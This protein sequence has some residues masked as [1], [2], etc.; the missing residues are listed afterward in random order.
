MDFNWLSVYSRCGNDCHRLMAQHSLYSYYWDHN[1]I[2]WLCIFSSFRVY[3]LVVMELDDT[4]FSTGVGSSSIWLDTLS[5]LS[6][7]FL[8]H[9]VKYGMCPILMNNMYYRKALEKW[10]NKKKEKPV[11][12]TNI[13]KMLIDGIIS[14]CK[15]MVIYF[16]FN[17]LL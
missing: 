3:I 13:Y 16:K 14:L 1:L 4:L 9:L 15:V 7:S 12:R 17:S 11:T 5:H 6:F 8:P 10:N 2:D